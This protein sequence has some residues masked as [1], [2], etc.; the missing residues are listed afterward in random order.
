MVSAQPS[1]R[2]TDSGAALIVT[3]MAMLL[4]SAI[5]AA[6]VLATS[7]DILIAANAGAAGEAFYA[8]D[9]AMERTIGELRGVPDFT[10]VLN[11]SIESAFTDGPP[12]GPRRLADGTP[13]SLNDVSNLAN[14]QKTSNCT[15]A[16][17]DASIRDRPWGARNPR[18]RLFSYGPLVPSPADA[19]SRLP[20]YVV[21]MVADDPA[22]TDHD[23]SQDGMSS[24]GVVNPGAGILLVRAEAYG[25]RGARRIVE[26]EIVRRDLVL[27]AA[28]EAGDPATRGPAPAGVPVLQVV[29]WREVR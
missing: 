25:R 23:P 12:S 3:L 17:L 18:W 28:W 4:L 21:S 20:V 14:C 11:G 1:D 13:L 5:G 22:E 16:D 24:G 8:A 9:A 7:A 19:A 29:A 2:A 26:C 27:R 15:Q 6:L 10:A